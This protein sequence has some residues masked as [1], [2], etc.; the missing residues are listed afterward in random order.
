MYRNKYTSQFMI[1]YLLIWRLS[2]PGSLV[3]MVGDHNQ[4]DKVDGTE[5]E[6][7]LHDQEEGE[8]GQELE[9]VLVDQGEPHTEHS[10]AGAA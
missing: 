8:Q 5:E 3:E 1:F 6:D 7:D 4:G 9:Q 10:I 2:A